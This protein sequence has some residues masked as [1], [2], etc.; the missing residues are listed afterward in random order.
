MSEKSTWKRQFN[1]L[2]SRVL[3]VPGRARDFI[4]Q[5]A[6]HINWLQTMRRGAQVLVFCAV[7]AAFTTLIWP[8][9]G[10]LFHLVHAL[11]IGGLCWL[12]IDLGRV[13]VAREHCRY[14]VK[15]DDPGWPKG[16]RSLALTAAG[17][18]TGFLG[19]RLLAMWLLGS[20]AGSSQR[21]LALALLITVAAVAVGACYFQA[22]DAQ[23]ALQTEIAVAERDA[24]EVR[25]KL[26]TA[27][28]EPHMLFNTLANLRALIGTNPAAAQRML[29]RM[30]GFLRASLKASRAT[31]H[32][33][34]AEFDCLR[35]YLALMSI[36]MGLRL[37]YALHLPDELR[38]QTV[39]PLILQPLVENAIR[40]G[41]EPRVEG[42]RI[43]VSAAR[44]GGTLTLTV[45]DTGVGFDASQPRT[46]RR[47]GLGQVMERVASARGG[48]G[49]VHVQS[50]PG[51]GTTIH[52]TLPCATPP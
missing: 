36:R 22:R 37:T 40:H 50:E 17:I 5:R 41:L 12:T 27:Q 34:Q 29:D 33:L 25:L 46:G 38:T 51:A 45:H 15:D 13:L 43:E 19:G 23:A 48:P 42:G 11:C 3:G 26:L 1:A 52:I 32:P 28:L 7:I 9:D 10:Y 16:W 47:F 8:S 35:D 21:D 30:D 49:Q 31:V 24:A 14:A 2:E 6:M 18:A 20:S 4:W 39:P 44:Q